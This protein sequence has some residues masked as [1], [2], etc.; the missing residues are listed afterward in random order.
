MTIERQLEITGYHGEAVPNLFYQQEAET[1][2][3][4]LIFPGFGYNADLPVLYYPNLIAQ[5][6][7]LDVLRLDT[8]YSRRPE[9]TRLGAAERLAWLDA[10]ASAALDAALAQRAYQRLLLIGKSIGTRA[11]GG[12]LQRYDQLPH[13]SWL[14]LTP[15]LTDPRLV[16]QIRLRQPRSLFV[17]GTA[18]DFY[19]PGTLNEL[20]QATDGG[21]VVIQ[22]GDHS[23]EIPG[24]IQLSLQALVQVMSAVDEW[25]AGV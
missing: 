19:Q 25:I 14:W 16:E 3:L 5:Q 21:L 11:M 2:G 12:L 20:V 17:I 24:Q 18:D 10:D 15:V 4:A 9:F 1:D 22:Q 23:L 8:A 13:S 6:H 7:N